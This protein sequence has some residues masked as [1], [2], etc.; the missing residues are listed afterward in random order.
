MTTDISQ[1]AKPIPGVLTANRLTDGAVVFL[2]AGGQ[3]SRRLDT[4]Y[5]AFGENTRDQLLA[6]GQKAETGNQVVGAYLIDVDLVA[7]DIVPRG[8]R[9]RIRVTGPTANG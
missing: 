1:A 7:G 9:E 5:L 2:A 8:L 6:R 3:W 4:A